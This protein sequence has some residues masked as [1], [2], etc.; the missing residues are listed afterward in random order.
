MLL[1]LVVPWEKKQ[2]E[3]AVELLSKPEAIWNVLVINGPSKLGSGFSADP[4][5]FLTP[6]TQFVRGI[7]GAINSQKL[8]IEPIFEGLKE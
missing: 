2:R 7:C 6:L 4:A 5:E 3:E 1:T 8:H